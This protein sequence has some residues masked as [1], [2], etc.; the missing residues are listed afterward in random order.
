MTEKWHATWMCKDKIKNALC[1]LGGKFQFIDSVQ[2]AEAQQAFVFD[3][4]KIFSLKSFW[5]EVTGY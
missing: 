3:K 4:K 5:G 2:F 1:S